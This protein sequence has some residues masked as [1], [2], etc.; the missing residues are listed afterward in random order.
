VPLQRGTAIL[1]PADGALMSNFNLLMA[2]AL[3][4]LISMMLLM[5]TLAIMAYMFNKQLN[6]IRTEMVDNEKA[7]TLENMQRWGPCTS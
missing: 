3:S 4:L 7:T 6:Q 5:V 1:I 2:L